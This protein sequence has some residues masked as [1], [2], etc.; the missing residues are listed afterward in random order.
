MPVKASLLMHL[1]TLY[2]LPVLWHFWGGFTGMMVSHTIQITSL[3]LGPTNISRI[4][5]KSRQACR[6][7]AMACPRGMVTHPI[8]CSGTGSVSLGS[9]G[10]SIK[11]VRPPEGGW[12]G[13]GVPWLRTE[14]TP[15][16]S[17]HN[18]LDGLAE[19]SHEPGSLQHAVLNFSRVFL[20]ENVHESWKR[21]SRSNMF[22]GGNIRI[23]KVKRKH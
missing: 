19:Q 16:S 6:A 3:S 20:S 14:W 21:D 7:S 11:P 22:W 9:H 2:I 18:K 10:R 17:L 4:L 5:S 23:N 15:C 13:P 8:C 1:F 12:W